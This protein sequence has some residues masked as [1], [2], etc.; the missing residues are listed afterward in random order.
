LLACSRTELTTKGGMASLAERVMGTAEVGWPLAA[1][2][3]AGRQRSS[4]HQHQ[5]RVVTSITANR[6]GARPTPN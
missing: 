5:V 1:G 3:P 6:G 2:C 4:E